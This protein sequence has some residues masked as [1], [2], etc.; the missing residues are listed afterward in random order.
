MFQKQQKQGRE[1]ERGEEAQ[2]PLRARGRL[3]RETAMPG[4][5][6]WNSGEAAHLA[7]ENMGLKYCSQ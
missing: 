4:R 5:R 1:G 2:A 3:T 7:A 6:E